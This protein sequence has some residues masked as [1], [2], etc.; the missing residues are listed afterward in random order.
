[1]KKQLTSAETR[2]KNG[3]TDSQ[4]GK[5]EKSH[6]DKHSNLAPAINTTLKIVKKIRKKY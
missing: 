2:S 5:F 3:N 6:S 4:P 1:M